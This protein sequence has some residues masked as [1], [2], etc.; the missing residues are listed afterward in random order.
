MPYA[1][2]LDDP[3]RG[4][5]HGGI[6]SRREIDGAV[7]VYTAPTETAAA[8]KPMHWHANPYFWMLVDG[9]CSERIKGVGERIY[10]PMT[11]T[12]HPR[13]EVHS[14]AS[15]P[16]PPSGFGI[17]LTDGLLARTK[18]AAPILEAPTVLLGYEFRLI[19]DRILEE[20]R[21]NDGASTLALEGLTIELLART[22]RA[23]V[24]TT[25]CLTAKLADSRDGTPARALR[26][27]T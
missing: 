10:T 16:R 3:S 12:Y 1:P 15:G 13:G 11:L 7:M 18:E 6:T 8:D 24:T 26:R 20:F 17:V 23:A 25:G 27:E 2:R 22:S 14:H 21:L 19:A 5:F 4:Q 9:D